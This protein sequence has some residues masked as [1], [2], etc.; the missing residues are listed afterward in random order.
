MSMMGGGMALMMIF[1]IIIIGLVI[2]GIVLLVSKPFEKK[3]DA[4]MQILKERFAKGEIDEQEFDDKM[5][6]LKKQN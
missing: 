6:R 5:A 4:S 1:W 2:Y 3:A